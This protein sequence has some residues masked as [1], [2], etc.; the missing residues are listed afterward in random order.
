M[1]VYAFGVLLCEIFSSQIPFFMMDYNAIRQR[2]LNGNRPQISNKTPTECVSL[3][4]DA[5][6]VFKNIDNY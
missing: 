6:Y 1:D 4:R 3:I 5:W 2:V